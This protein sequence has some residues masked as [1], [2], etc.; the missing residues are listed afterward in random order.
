MRVT[1]LMVRCH[2]WQKLTD[3]LLAVMDRR[4]HYISEQFRFLW[5]K[6]GTSL[7]NAC[8]QLEKISTQTRG[9]A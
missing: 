5:L 8:S 1:R 7:T 4:R 9:L 2:T 3:L 6:L